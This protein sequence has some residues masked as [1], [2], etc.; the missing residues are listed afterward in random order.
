MEVTTIEFSE[1]QSGQ[2]MASPCEGQPE[3][4]VAVHHGGVGRGGVR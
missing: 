1:E 3:A 2:S 4:R